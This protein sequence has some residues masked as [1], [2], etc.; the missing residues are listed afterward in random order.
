MTI[1]FSRLQCSTV[2]NYWNVLLCPPKLQSILFSRLSWE[3]NLHRVVSF[4]NHFIRLML[5]VIHVCYVFCLLSRGSV[6]SR[7]KNVESMCCA[8]NIKRNAFNILTLN[9][10]LHVKEQPVYWL[11]H[12]KS[13]AAC[14]C[15]NNL[16]HIETFIWSNKM[17]CASQF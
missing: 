7:S 11:A 8:I 6:N 13:L 15:F 17:F 5:C 12:S 3:Y 10:K 9:R 16:Q 4:S 14:L 1:G 2:I